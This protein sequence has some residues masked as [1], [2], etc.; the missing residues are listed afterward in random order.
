MDCDVA[1]IGA[2]AAGLSAAAILKRAGLEV[3]CVEAGNRVG[4]RIFTI[5]DSLASLPIELGAEFVHGRPP[6]IWKLIESQGLT[7][8]EHSAEAI[9]LGRGHIFAEKETGEIADGVLEKMAKSTRRKDESFEDYLRHSRQPSNIKNWARIHIEGFNAASA[10]EVSAAFLIKDAEA[11]EEIEGDRIFRIANG[12]DSLAAALLRSIPDHSSTVQLNSLVRRVKWRR[13][14]VDVAYESTLDRQ[15]GTL[16][17]RQLIVTVPLGVLQATPDNRGAI[18]F[19]PEP[20]EILNAAASLRFGQVYRVT[21]RFRSRFWEEDEK[22][23]RAAFLIS[24]DKRFFAWWTSYPMLMPLLT[25]WMAGSAADRF[26]SADEGRIAGEAL[27]SLARILNRKVPRPEA[28]YFH[29]WRTDPF[30]RGAYSYVPVGGL[31]A[32]A[33]L[34]KPVEGTLFFAG[35]ATERR[36]HGGTVHGAMASGVRAAELVQAALDRK[37]RN[38]A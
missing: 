10:E 33:A 34:S 3:C 17:C 8:Y 27:E 29:N 38:K 1:I 35:E 4:G 14:S 22:L 18:L 30:F 28:A 15:T 24:Q 6:E 13:G 36:G 5:H 11:A 20:G 9:H 26:R 25:G 23:K 16:H 2:G 31:S 7:A 37:T 19:D 32:R 12:Y 21:F